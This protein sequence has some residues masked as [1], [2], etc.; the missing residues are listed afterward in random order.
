MKIELTAEDRALDVR[1]MFEETNG[2]IELLKNSRIEVPGEAGVMLSLMKRCIVAEETIADHH[3][4]LRNDSDLLDLAWGVIANVGG[5]DWSKESDD[6]R[7]AAE[8]WRDAFFAPQ[9]A[10]TA[11]PPTAPPS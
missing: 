5:G 1:K 9:S 6:W 10:V 11:Q 8:S 2:V 3:R 4:G 7:G